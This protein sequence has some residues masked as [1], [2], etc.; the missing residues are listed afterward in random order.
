MQMPKSFFTDVYRL[1]AYLIDYDLD[2]K[3]KALCE[4]LESQLNAKLE[5]ISRREA[6]TAYKTA[7]ASTVQRESARQE[8]IRKAYVP[9]GFVSKKEIHF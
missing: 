3:T 9:A 2:D 7:P 6:F 5:A 8:Y 1:L 4:R